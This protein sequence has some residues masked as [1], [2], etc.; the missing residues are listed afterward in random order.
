MP[1]VQWSAEWLDRARAAVH[2][3]QMLAGTM[4]AAVEH[5]PGDLPGDEI[6]QILA[7]LKEYHANIAS[8][9]ATAPT[10]MDTRV[11]REL[12]IRTQALSDPYVRELRMREALGDGAEH[13]PELA[14]DPM[15]H[16]AR[17]L[18]QFE[19]ALRDLDEH[20]ELL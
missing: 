5:P 18:E 2:D 14:A 8:V 13:R 9:S 12:G 3:G 16:P 6:S 11:C 1:D 19:V 20:V 7:D 15:Q 17:R 4:T 10:A